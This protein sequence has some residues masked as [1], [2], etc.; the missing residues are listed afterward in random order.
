M[1]GRN[2]ILAEAPLPRTSRS[3]P[4]SS[5]LRAGSVTPT[6][7]NPATSVSIPSAT[8]AT[9]NLVCPNTIN[10]TGSNVATYT[11]SVSYSGGTLTFSGRTLVI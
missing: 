2:F 10:F 6:A 4:R 5:P 9:F 8:S 1:F 11:I 3:H 7:I